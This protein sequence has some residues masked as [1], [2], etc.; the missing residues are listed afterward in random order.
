MSRGKW[1]SCNCDRLLKN[2]W[3]L[4]HLVPQVC[5]IILFLNENNNKQAHEKFPGH[6]CWLV[7]VYGIFQVLVLQLE[8]LADSVLRPH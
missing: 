6:S 2:G 7:N 3:F 8:R 1:N 4:E 5:T